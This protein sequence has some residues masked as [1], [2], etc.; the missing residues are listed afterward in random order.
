MTYNYKI[1]CFIGHR[2]TTSDD[3]QNF[4][5]HL[6]ELEA[7]LDKTIEYLISE[8]GVQHF[9]C[10]N[11]IG[12]DMWEAQAVL[13][14]K[15][16]YPHVILEIAVPYEGRNATI[17]EVVEI[18]KNADIVTIV[19]QKQNRFASYTERD[20]YMQNKSDVV[21]GVVPLV[22]GENKT[23]STRRMLLQARAH[24][25]EMYTKEYEKPICKGKP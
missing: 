12:I 5:S 6:S 13:K 15:K 11:D 9:I 1:A 3:F 18:Q 23:R 24:G 8:R 10:G 2:A 7:W 22:D 19:S 14:H 20:R 25:K 16:L 17:S 4:E 21:V